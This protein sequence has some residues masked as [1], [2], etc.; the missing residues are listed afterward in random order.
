MDLSDLKRII[1][2]AEDLNLPEDTPVKLAIQPRWPFTYKVAG[3]I[4]APETPDGE[5][6][7][8]LAEYSQ[9][10]YL[11]DTIRDTLIDEGIW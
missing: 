5:L 8:Y 10:K 7:I 3:G 6:V 1:E 9:E 2:E 4:I 11:P